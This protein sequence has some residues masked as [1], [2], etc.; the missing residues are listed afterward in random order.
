MSLKDN[1]DEQEFYKKLGLFIEI[2]QYQSR[3][4][5]LTSGGLTNL[6]KDDSIKKLISD[7]MLCN[8]KKGFSKISFFKLLK[9][10][11]FYGYNP[12]QFITEFIKYMKTTRGL[13]D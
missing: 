3:L 1:K 4:D 7:E 12:H 10:S 8:Y 5:T 9:L 6:S 11:E 13:N 2:M